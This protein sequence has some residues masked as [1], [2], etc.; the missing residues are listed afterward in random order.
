MEPII[1]AANL[2]EFDGRNM[3]GIMQIRKSLTR[4]MGN[5]KAEKQ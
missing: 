3:D 4:P 5:R 1:F 2:R